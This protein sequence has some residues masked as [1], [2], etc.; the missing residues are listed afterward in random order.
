MKVRKFPFMAG[1]S[2]A[3]LLVVAC[4]DNTNQAAQQLTPADVMFIKQQRMQAM[5]GSTV[6]NTTTVQSVVTI[7]NSTTVNA[8]H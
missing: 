8:S 1:L 4:G 7:T 6:T 3:A 5:Y 2:L